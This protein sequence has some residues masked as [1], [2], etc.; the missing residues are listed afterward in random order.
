MATKRTET[1]P[2]GSTVLTHR[3]L[4]DYSTSIVRGNP[5]GGTP[6]RWRVEPLD[7]H[8]LRGLEDSL[9]EWGT[10]KDDDAFRNL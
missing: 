6:E 5:E 4:D 8:F 9:D 1:F 7:M 2:N 10:P 3:E